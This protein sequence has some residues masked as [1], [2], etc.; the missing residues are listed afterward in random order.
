MTLRVLLNEYNLVWIGAAETDSVLF[1][2]TTKIQTQLKYTYLAYC[3]VFFVA[4]RHVDHDPFS[5][6]TFELA[7]DFHETLYG[8]WATSS[9][10]LQLVQYGGREN[11]RGEGL[12]L[13]SLGFLF[14]SCKI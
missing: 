10:F 2:F 1:Y 11:L 5:V 14:R 4:R 12:E 7:D 13:L 8:T 9:V 3:T 6:V